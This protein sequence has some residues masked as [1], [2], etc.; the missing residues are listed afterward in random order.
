LRLRMPL[1]ASGKSQA[2]QKQRR[3]FDR[4]GHMSSG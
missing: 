2:E 1:H 4:N 3:V